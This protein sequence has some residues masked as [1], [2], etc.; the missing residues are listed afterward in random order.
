MNTLSASTGK[1]SIKEL[2][3]K[4]AAEADK[5]KTSFAPPLRM[6]PPQKKKWEAY[7]HPETGEIWW[8]CEETGEAMFTKP[9]DL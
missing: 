7:T 1:S 6:P 2:R 9:P 8:W 5:Q 4:E 3:A